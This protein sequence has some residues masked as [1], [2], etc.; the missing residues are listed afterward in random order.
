MYTSFE[1]D[2][3]L[4]PTTVYE[5]IDVKASEGWTTALVVGELSVLAAMPQGP[6]VRLHSRC[7]WGEVLASCECDCGPQLKTARERI[8]EEGAG[9]LFYM[10]E[11]EGRGAGL[12]AKAKGYRLT[13]DEGLDTF[14]A[15]E[16]IGVPLDQREYDH[17]GRFLGW[18][19]IRRVRLLTNNP[20]KIRALEPWVEVERMPLD[21]GHTQENRDYRKAKRKHGHLL[22]PIT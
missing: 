20:D 11:Q 10:H 6:L 9:I 3:E 4:G 1:A 17:C 12:A 16:R 2:T 18:T 19:G 7:A 21:V 5:L 13:E 15:Y 22:G 14:A 8:A